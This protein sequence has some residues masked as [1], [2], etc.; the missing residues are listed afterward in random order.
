MVYARTKLMMQDNCFPEDPGDVQLKYVGPH[1]SKIYQ[2]LYEIV[3]SVFNV[4]SS[5]IQ[6]DKYNWG[7]GETE[8]FKVNWLIH[9]DVDNFSYMYL[10]VSISAEGTEKMGNATIRLKPYLRT[11][12]PQDT[13]W[14]RSL[15]YEFVRTFW[16]RTFY[17]HRRDEMMEECR[18]IS[19][20]LQKKMQELFRELREMA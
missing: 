10:K 2:R 20:L 17:H 18:H 13:L 4:P 6:E 3:K 15:F 8:K 9:K 16:H 1:V 7:K 14:Q 5:A 12:Y 19:I 11:E